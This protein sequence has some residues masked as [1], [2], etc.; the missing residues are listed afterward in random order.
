MMPV[1]RPP[2]YE[3]EYIYE[4]VGSDCC[5]IPVCHTFMYKIHFLHIEDLFS[6]GRG[7]FS[8]SRLRG[9]QGGRV[10]TTA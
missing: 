10:Y 2:R 6:S 9:T 4:G 8:R 3:Y 1:P 5:A 7:S